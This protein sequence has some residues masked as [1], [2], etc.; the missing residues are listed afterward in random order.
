MDK[1]K[2][3][4]NQLI[5]ENEPMNRNLILLSYGYKE[6]KSK[7]IKKIKLFLWRISNS[8]KCPFCNSELTEHGFE[9][10]NQRYT[11]NKNCEFNNE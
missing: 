5:L 3:I 7:I 6:K 1:V 9:G 10:Y 11:C 4:T 8:K 2:L